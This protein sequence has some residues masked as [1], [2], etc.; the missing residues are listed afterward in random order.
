MKYY[1]ALFLGLLTG[2]AIVIGFLFYNPLTG[3]ASLSPLQVSDIEQITLNYSAVSEASII[4]TNDGE[5]R[6]GIF[7]RVILC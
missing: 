2:A 6:A 7:S 3:Q 4:L 1:I 5:S